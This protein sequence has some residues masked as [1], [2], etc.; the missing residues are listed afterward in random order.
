MGKIGTG[1]VWLRIGNIGPGVELIHYGMATGGTYKSRKSL[2]VFKSL[3]V[4]RISPGLMRA[5]LRRGIPTMKFSLLLINP[6]LYSN[7][8][9]LYHVALYRPGTSIWSVHLQKAAGLLTLRAK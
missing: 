1:G 6:S 7:F 2:C 9:P 4:F 3:A 8:S 5:C